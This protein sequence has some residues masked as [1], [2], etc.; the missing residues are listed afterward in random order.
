MIINIDPE[1]IQEDRIYFAKKFDDRIGA[2][3]D[4]VLASKELRDI[5]TA[6]LRRIKAELPDTPIEELKEMLMDEDQKQINPPCCAGNDLKFKLHFEK[7]KM[8]CAKCDEVEAADSD[9]YNL[10]DF[11]NL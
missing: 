5:R 2:F 1:N 11:D 9:G 10:D 7:F 3:K 6:E 4:L 8:A